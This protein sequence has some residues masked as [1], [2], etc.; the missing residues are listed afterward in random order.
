M[1]KEK[2]LNK[3][4]KSIIE[5]LGYEILPEENNSERPIIVKKE[6]KESLPVEKTR[7]SIWSAEELETEYVRMQ[8]DPGI[9]TYIF[10]DLENNLDIYLYENAGAELYITDPKNNNQKIIIKIYYDRFND[11]MN[12]TIEDKKTNKS[13]QFMYYGIDYNE[14]SWKYYY[15]SEI[16]I[17]NV[18]NGETI[19]GLS[20]NNN[21][22]WGDFKNPYPI[23]R[24]SFKNVS[25]Y[26]I[27]KIKEYKDGEY[28]TQGIRK[29]IDVIAPALAIYIV[30][31]KKDWQTYLEAY[32]QSEIE[33]QNE[34]QKQIGYIQE[35]IQKSKNT[36]KSI[37]KALKQ[38]GAIPE[39]RLI[40]K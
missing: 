4:T 29:G 3:Y 32:R 40:K 30:D 37:T 35:E 11:E 21:L 36:N 19:I 26:L 8:D 20:P 33:R 22:K 34:K 38:L 13:V 14:R 9:L 16:K 28:W 6:T 5:G 24:Y 18:K 25:T 39:Q 27:K 31:F 7:F 15:R 1:K 23:T 2:F 12:I 17:S 10:K